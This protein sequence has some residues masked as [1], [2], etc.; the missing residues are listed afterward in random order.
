MKKFNKNIFLFILVTLFLITG[1]CSQGLAS[2]LFAS[3]KKLYQNVV[4]GNKNAFQTFTKEVDS[5]SNQLRYH[6]RMLDI[7]SV[8]DNLL[9]TRVMFEDETTVV[10]SD[11]GSLLGYLFTTPSSKEEIAGW[12]GP[13]KEVQAIAEA[14]GAGFLYCEIPEKSAYEVL[15]P[16]YP[17][18]SAQNQD[19]YLQAILSSD[20]PTFISSAMFK[21]QGLKGDDIFFKTDHHWTPKAGFFVHSG[22]CKELKERYGFE[23]N[24]QYTDLNNYNIKTYENW[25]LGSYGKKCGTYFTG[26]RVDDFDLITPKFETDFTEEIPVKNSIRNGSFEDTLL[27]KEYLA[28]DYYIFNNYITYSGGDFRLQKIIN[29]KIEN[30]KKIL[31]I[32]SSFGCVVTPFLALHAKELHVIDTRDG[33][34]PAGEKVNVEEYIKE[35]KPDYVIYLM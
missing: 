30:G 11:S 3:T 35:I 32:R 27:Y 14:N 1:L 24:S 20:I 15:P 19:I 10:K 13:I 17:A 4:S 22:I 5:S 31:V 16:N 34:Y 23:Y 28:K 21:E 33:D 26:S 7:T 18:Y 25:F 9:G 6:S 8:K 12:T 2:H 29:N